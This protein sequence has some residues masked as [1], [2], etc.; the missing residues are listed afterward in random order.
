M[1]AVKV[2][3]RAI[4]LGVLGRTQLASHDSGVSMHHRGVALWFNVEEK[5]GVWR[6]VRRF[7]SCQILL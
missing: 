2:G 1:S 6:D 5:A 3:I 7:H 4:M